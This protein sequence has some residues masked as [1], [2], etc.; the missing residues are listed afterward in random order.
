MRMR[1]VFICVASIV[2][3][4][5][6]AQDADPQRTDRHA[7]NYFRTSDQCIACH[8]G[9]SDSSGHD[10]SIGYAWRA[11]MM[12]QSARDPYWHAAVRREVTDHP[13]AQQAIEDKCSTCH[14]P[15]ARFGDAHQGGE[16]HVF[17][18]LPVGPGVPPSAFAA[19]GVS[20][21]VCHQIRADNLGTEESLD[22]GFEID[23]TTPFAER[24]IYGP[25][26]VDDG[27]RSVMQSAGR[28]VT[29]EGAQIQTSELC[30]T[31]HTLYT[32]AMNDAGEVVGHLPEQVPYQEWAHSDYRDRQNCQSCHMPVLD[33]EAPISSIL[34]QLRP[35]FSQHVFRGGNAFIL[36][37]LNRHRGE[38][39]VAATSQELDASVK[40]TKN[41]LANETARVAISGARL[42]GSA[43]QFDVTVRSL[44][45]HKLPTAYPAR[46]VWLHVTVTSGG[47]TVFESGAVRPDGSIVGN[48]NDLDAGRYEPHYQRIDSADQVQ[49][50]ESIMVDHADRVTTGLLYGMRYIKDNRLL[51]SGFDK[52]TAEEQVAVHGAALDDEDFTAGSDRVQY[53]VRL[54]RSVESAHVDVQLYFQSI[55]YRWAEN[56][57]AYDTAETNR[58]V[59]YYGTAARDSALP[60]AS[61]SADVP[62]R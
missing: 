47:N 26:Q 31:C 1:I 50:Y 5:V 36:G 35:H 57:K 2:S 52:R 4:A 44:S 33:E 27:R 61:A 8:S 41:F 48:D 56:L 49:I 3:F 38:L 14:M 18:N 39:N 45:G 34:G 9:M 40:R 23:T 17:A 24:H 62:R 59:S 25:H 43:L 60:L 10:I 29:G 58:F 28:F 54:G 32:D 21:T 16:G 46:R 30:A 53:R 37:I 55:G 20:C 22:G 19:D 42:T 7:E 13:Q 6:R 51:P 15:M 12:A 11:S